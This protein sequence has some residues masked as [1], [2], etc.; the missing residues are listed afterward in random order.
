MTET[1][2]IREEPIELTRLLKFAGL[3]ESGGQA[4][5][6]V[7]S[8]EVTV[9]GAIETQARKKIFSGTTVTCAGRTLTVQIASGTA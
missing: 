4:K 1:I 8:G 6:A 7:N 2:V 9:N 3:F 5:V